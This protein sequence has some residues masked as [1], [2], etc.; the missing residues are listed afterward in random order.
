MPSTPRQWQRVERGG[1]MRLSGRCVTW[2]LLVA[3]LLGTACGTR[4]GHDDIVGA[5]RTS[6]ATTASPVA[7][8]DDGPSIAVPGDAGAGVLEQVAS[9]GRASSSP[10]VATGR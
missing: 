10:S 4:L 8:V 1:R 3:A 6:R 9:P 5:G 7:A 2:A